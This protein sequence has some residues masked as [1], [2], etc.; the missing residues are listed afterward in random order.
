MTSKGMPLS[1]LLSN[2]RDSL[3][4]KWFDRVVRAYP[5]STSNFLSREKDRFRNPV[6]HTLKEG[7]SALFDG[8]VQEK[9]VASLDSVLDDIVKMRAVQDFSASQA[10]SFPLL[11]KKIIQEECAADVSGHQAEYE[12]LDA[13]IDSLTLLAFDLYMKRR[14]RILE[15]KNNEAKRSMFLLERNGQNGRSRP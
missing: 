5:E 8:L 7:L 1:A 15:I 12:D 13:R 10:V 11:L 6:G 3:V 14:E 2:R 9:D 4:N